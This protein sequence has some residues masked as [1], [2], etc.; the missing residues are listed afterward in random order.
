[1]AIDPRRVRIALSALLAAL[2]TM[3][4]L[5]AGADGAHAASELATATQAGHHR[6]VGLRAA[7]SGGDRPASDPP[8]C[9]RRLS[10]AAGA[11]T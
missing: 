1:M 5:L 4:M 11:V 8:P 10:P 7:D 6:A 3:A 9:L 2:L